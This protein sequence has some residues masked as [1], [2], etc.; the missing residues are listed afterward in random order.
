[1]TSGFMETLRD[2]GRGGGGPLTS[3]GY[4]GGLI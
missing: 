2:E 3:I 1:M 4:M